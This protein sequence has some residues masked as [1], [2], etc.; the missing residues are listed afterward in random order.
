MC[1]SYISTTNEDLR[2]KLGKELEIHYQNYDV[3]VHSY[4]LIRRKL[5]ARKNR[6]FKR[7]KIGSRIRLVCYHS[8]LADWIVLAT[9]LVFTDSFPL[10]SYSFSFEHGKGCGVLAE[11]V[12]KVVWKDWE[13]IW[14][15]NGNIWFK[16]LTDG[17]YFSDF[18]LMSKVVRKDRENDG[19]LTEIFNLKL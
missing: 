3:A 6:D 2:L 9:K 7:A 12:W 18:R 8:C 19:I 4:L 16:T 10:K 17:N 14:I 15:F 13:K 11:R 1:N 5:L